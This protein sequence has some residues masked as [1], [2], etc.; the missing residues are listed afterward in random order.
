MRGLSFCIM[1]IKINSGTH[2]GFVRTNIVIDDDLM[3][4]ALKAGAYASKKQAVEEGLKF[5]VRLNAQKSAKKYRG[6][7]QWV[8]NL[9]RLRKD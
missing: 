3:R 8:G 4:A 9:D 2:G 5:L 6:K 1:C 7:L